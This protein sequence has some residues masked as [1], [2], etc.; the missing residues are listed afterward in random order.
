MNLLNKQKQ[1]I[2]ESV[3]ALKHLKF[4]ENHGTYVVSLIDATGYEIIR[5][6]GTTA[7]EAL[8]DLHHNL[9]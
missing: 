4:E 3:Y 9:L 7:V 5:G 6:F 8:N 1:E 2:S